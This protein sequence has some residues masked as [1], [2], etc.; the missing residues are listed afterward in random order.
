MKQSEK[1]SNAYRTQGIAY[2]LAVLGGR[3]VMLLLGLIR[4]FAA[5]VLLLASSLLVYHDKVID[6]S[7]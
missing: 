4:L 6:L 1:R 3:F 2:L 7:S 5:R